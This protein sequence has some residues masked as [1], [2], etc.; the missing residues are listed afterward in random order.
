MSVEKYKRTVK[1]EKSPE[2][3][4]PVAP[5]V[6]IEK[7]KPAIPSKPTNGVYCEKGEDGKSAYEI[8]IEVG[9]EG[10]IEDFLESLKGEKG[11]DGK[12]GVG[13][14]GKDGVDGEDA[15]HGLQGPIGPTGPASV[16]SIDEEGVVDGS[17]Q[18]QLIAA[19]PVNILTTQVF[20]NGQKLKTANY[21]IDGG[22]LVTINFPTPDGLSTE[23]VSGADINV[24]IFYNV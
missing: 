17:N 9:N 3:C 5:Q 22:G 21:T 15:K 8:W 16:A 20:L 4:I 12:D 2:L 23:D 6:V 19:L 7:Y 10:T 1:V 13:K 14:A 24:I 18:Y 11:K